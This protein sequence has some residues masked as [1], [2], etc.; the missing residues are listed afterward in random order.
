MSST[1]KKRKASSGDDAVVTLRK[2]DNAEAVAEALLSL[3]PKSATVAHKDAKKL[4]RAFHLFQAQLQHR[5][6]VLAQNATDAGASQPLRIAGV[7]V[8]EEIF[9]KVL[10]FL[11]QKAIGQ[12]VP[13]VSKAW[14]SAARVPQVWETVKIS[15]AFGANHKFSMTE[16]LAILQQKHMSH[17]KHL[18]LPGKIKFGK[19]G[20]KKLAAACPML[21]TLDLKKMNPDDAQ[22]LQCWEHFPHL[23]GLSFTMWKTTG[24][25]VAELAKVAGHRLRSLHV[26]GSAITNS[27]LHD[28][29][30]RTIAAHCPNLREFAYHIWPEKCQY[31]EQSCD[32]GT[33]AGLIALVQGCAA[34]QTLTI[35]WMPKLGL[36]FFQY[37][38]A[39]TSE[40]HNLQT[41]QTRHVE[42]VGGPAGQGLAELLAVKIPNL[43]LRAD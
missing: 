6:R 32:G 9:L 1:N 7:S 17:V 35:D 36:E 29:D 12:T 42:C 16:V 14:L 40:E 5:S 11:P 27:F 24:T 4:N 25:G 37:L 26:E 18:T 13:L 33:H 39:A 43:D 31:Y 38:A 8:P 34:L 41:L 3:V 2:S 15:N 19:S 10:Q 20:M 28:R 21:E 30:L 22:L 23:T